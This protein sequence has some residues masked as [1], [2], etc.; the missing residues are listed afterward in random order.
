MTATSLGTTAT[1]P[2]LPG[3]LAGVLLDATGDGVALLD[4]D[5]IVLDCSTPLLA[6]CA[7]TREALIGVPLWTLL[8][9]PTP[10]AV[11]ERFAAAWRDGSARSCVTGRRPD[12]EAF[13]ADLVLR[14]L[15]LD[16]ATC[17]LGVFCVRGAALTA[18]ATAARAGPAGAQ[19]GLWDWTLPTDSLTWVSEWR[20]AAGQRVLPAGSA[21]PSWAARVDG[22][23][24]DR[25]GKTLH[26]HLAGETAEFDIEYR[27]RGRPVWVHERGWV[28]ERDVDGAAR[29][30]VGVSAFVDEQRLLEPLY[31]RDAAGFEH[32]L[33]GTHVGFW[34]IDV[35]RDCLYWW[36]DWCAAVDIDPCAGPLYRRRWLQRVHPDDLLQAA[37]F[38]TVLDGSTSVYETEYRVRTRSGGWRWIL[39]RGRATTRDVD[40]RATHVAGVTIDIDARKRA[41]LALD[42]SEA[43]LETAVWGTNIGLWVGAADGTFRFL[44]DWCE[45]FGLDPCYGP[46]QRLRWR[47]ELHPDD[48][49]SFARIND[50][51]C[52]GALEQYDMEYRVRRRGGGWLWV[53]ERARVISR[54]P[55]GA[56]DRL[57]G[58]CYDV[59]ARKQMEAALRLAQDRYDLAIRAAQ[60]PVWEY[61]VVTD[62]LTGNVYWHRAMGR[63]LDEAAAALHRETGLSDVHPDDRATLARAYRMQGGDDTDFYEAEYRVRLPGGEYKWLLDRA[64]VVSRDAAG[65]PTRLVGIALD[66]DVRKR[67]EL[68]LRAS[69]VRLDTVVGGSDIGLWDWSMETDRLQWLSDWPQR[70]GFHL[71]QFDSRGSDWSA[72]LDPRDR[73]RL[74]A[75]HLAVVRGLK[76]SHEADYRV[77]TLAG[78]W[79][80]IRVR[81]RVIERDA[82]GR[83]LRMVGAC[84]DVDAR[85]R[86]EE[87]LQTQAMILATMREGVALIDEGGRVALSNPAFERVFAAPGGGLDESG[88][89][90]LLAHLRAPG[91]RTGADAAPGRAVELRVRRGDGSE[92]TAEVV[93]GWVELD[94]DR[95]ALVVVQDVSERKALEREVLEIASREQHRLGA[96][97]HDGLGQELTGIALMLRSVATRQRRGAPVSAA[98]IDELVTL[99][100]GAIESTRAV[101]HGLSPVTLQPGGLTAALR[102]LAR[103]SRQ[104]Y[105][106]RVRVRWKRSD[107]TRVEATMA[108]HLYRIVQE[109]LANAVKHG[110]A[111]SVSILIRVGTD[112]V[113]LTVSDDGIGMPEDLAPAD[114]M[115][116]KLMAYRAKLMGGVIT[117]RSRPGHGT[118][119]ECSCPLPAG[120]P[121]GATAH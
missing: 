81:S 56:V 67:M 62:T 16:G 101:A 92:F 89:G 116:L 102:S 43:R 28:V 27:L 31:A 70:H 91:Q 107:E 44:N 83:A 10:T 99:V 118:R 111:Q 113:A 18:V 21:T 22:N 69:E 23:D 1:T 60:L 65:L 26:R 112:G 24:A 73:E 3:G 50:A 108:D 40:G 33:W 14:P 15:C 117:V 87:L 82:A 48:L 34:E 98:E 42:E 103:R 94:A 86:A 75:N 119:I 47:D 49:A 93:S 41:E 79:Q 46:D 12:G 100:N 88:F 51:L 29:R 85:H 36:N 78:D 54:T 90:Q 55:A 120:A 45:R 13:V 121:R 84:I 57:A 72:I 63:A 19:V 32:A 8:E 80:W 96:D 114:G 76:T 4:P 64:R 106:I 9:S 97:L 30:M 6:L 17:L 68:S 52:D 53:Q 11:R 59:D 39:T 5:G 58:V 115:G 110:R 109:A 37:K 35:T 104:I 7:R 38:E 66:I 25:Y 20:D 105:G 95:K 71:S 2:A 61:D 74:H 77:R